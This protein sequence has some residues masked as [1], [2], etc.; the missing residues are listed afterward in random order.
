MSVG[1][2]ERQGGV[3][4]FFSLSNT[5]TQMFTR[6][7]RMRISGVEQASHGVT[8]ANSVIPDSKVWPQLA[9]CHCLAFEFLIDVIAMVYPAI[10]KLL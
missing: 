3:A 4:Q 8:C 5:A 1:E 6:G 9:V 7:T 10:G 2:R